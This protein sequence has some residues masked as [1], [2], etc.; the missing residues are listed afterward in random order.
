LSGGDYEMCEWGC[1]CGGDASM[2]VLSSD[3]R[4][5]TIRN[6]GTSFS[7]PLAA[8]LAAKI[9]RKYPNIKMQSVK[10]LIINSA[11]KPNMG[12]LFSGLGDYCE[13]RVVGHGIPNIHR[14]LFSDENQV[15]LLLE[16]EINIGNV[17][18]FELN[19]PE[20]L[21]E[22]GRKNGLLKIKATL[23]FSFYPV[24]N[25]QLLYCPVHVG[26]SICKNMPLL[27]DNGE[28]TINGASSK[29]IKLSNIGWSQDY[30]NKA[31]AVSNTQKI[32]FN[33]KRDC[34][35]LEENKFKVVVN[36]AFHKFM[37]EHLKEAYAKSIQFSLIFNIEQCPLKNEDL[38]NL[39]DE[40]VAVNT[41]ESIADVDIDIELDV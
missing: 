32:E 10:A 8:N 28:V 31:P 29:D 30:F 13:K 17:K 1:V 15:T 39:Y 21:N 2:E 3:L 9:I 23:C 25:I 7:V 41:L 19:I 27:S 33:I 20:Y 26:F 11:V 4:D 5:R 14:M 36:S 35:I 38:G 37:P 34:I 22:A 40:L 16:D 6:I 12:E 18:S 24:E